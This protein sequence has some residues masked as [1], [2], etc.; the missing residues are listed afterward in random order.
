MIVYII[1]ITTIGISIIIHPSKFTSALFTA[2][3]I[4]HHTSS[5][6]LLF[7]AGV[8]RGDDGVSLLSR[9]LFLFSLLLLLLLV[10]DD[11]KNDV[12]A[13]SRIHCRCKDL[14]WILK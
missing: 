5:R 11:D 13:F 3:S 1:I 4:R 6:F 7:V 14:L 8:K 10:G 9:F 2:G 12:S